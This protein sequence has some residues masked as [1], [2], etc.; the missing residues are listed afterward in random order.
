MGLLSD[1]EVEECSICFGILATHT[2]SVKVK[3]I[4]VKVTD[5]RYYPPNCV[6]GKIYT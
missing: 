2:E 5:Y 4:V 6:P 3:L 1:H